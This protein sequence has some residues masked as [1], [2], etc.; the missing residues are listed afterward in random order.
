M[1]LGNVRED[2][3]LDPVLDC[4]I[5]D[6][7][8]HRCLERT[9]N[10]R[11]EGLPC[12][13]CHIPFCKQKCAYCDFPSVAGHEADMETYTDALCKE[14]ASKGKALSSQQG[15]TLKRST[16]PISGIMITWLTP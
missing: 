13:T 11:L 2:D 3:C 8:A 14:L 6:S 5:A 10:G 16:I 12:R 4:I 1:T 15:H 9:E 7:L